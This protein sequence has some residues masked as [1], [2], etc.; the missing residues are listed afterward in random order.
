MTMSA[1]QQTAVSARMTIAY[2]GM[3]ADS[4]IV[5]HSDSKYNQEASAEIRFG[6]GVVRGATDEDNSAVKPHTSAAAAAPLFCGIVLHSHDYAPDIEIGTTGVKPKMT[7]NVLQKGRVYV[8][9]E[10][11]VD[12]GDPVRMRVV[13]AGSEVAGAFRTSADATDC[14]NLSTVA[15]W[16]TSGS[17]TIPAV[18]EIDLTNA[19]AI[20]A[21]T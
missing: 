18:L 14:I 17:T 19:A 3:L 1:G 10:E 8:L 20:T 16:I 7:L 13:V 4:T 9:P 5:K 21:D 15:R 11:D 6:D 2:A 12:P